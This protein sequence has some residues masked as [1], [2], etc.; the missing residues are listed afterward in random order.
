[1]A[2][3]LAQRN[4]QGGA[5]GPAVSSLES[6]DTCS[7]LHPHSPVPQQMGAWEVQC[8]QPTMALVSVLRMAKVSCGVDITAF[9]LLSVYER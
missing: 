5:W 3:V 1:M 4:S 9:L 2:L 8:S 7:V 6:T